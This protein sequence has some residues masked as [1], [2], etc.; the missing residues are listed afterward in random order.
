[1]SLRRGIRWIQSTVS[2]AK[3]ACPSSEKM[4]KLYKVQVLEYRSGWC[5]DE[6]TRS[7]ILFILLISLHFSKPE[8]NGRWV[9]VDFQLYRHTCLGS[10][11]KV[12]INWLLIHFL[13]NDRGMKKKEGWVV[14]NWT[15]SEF[16]YDL[17]DISPKLFKF[18][19]CLKVFLSLPDIANIGLTLRK[20]ICVIVM[21]YDTTWT[22]FKN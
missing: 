5:L 22:E 10:V 11:K 9:S 17:T 13:R 6:R 1:M 19:T 21:V 16:L 15:I 2:F 3:S 18:G 4:N 12:A 7:S 8:I 14:G 20:R